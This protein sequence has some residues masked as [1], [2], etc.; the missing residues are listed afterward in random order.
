M[1][2]ERN[3]DDENYCAAF[4]EHSAISQN[5][6]ERINRIKNN[7]PDLTEFSPGP[8]D[9][10]QFT[11]LAWELLGGYIANNDHLDYI[12]LSV[13]GLTDSKISLLFQGLAN[14]SPLKELDLSHNNLGV[15]GVRRMVPFLESARNLRELCLSDNRDTNTECFRLLIKAL[16]AGGGY[17]QELR[18]WDGKIEDITSLEHYPLPHL[19]VLY[20]SKNNIHS[21]PTSLE[22]YTNLEELHL[23]NNQIGNEGCRSIAKLLQK[24]GTHL[25]LLNLYSNDLGDEDAETLADSLKYNTSLTDIHLEGNDIKEKGHRAFL[26]LVNDVSSIERTYNSNHTLK[27]LS[28]PRSTDA[29]IQEFKTHIES[30]MGINKYE[31]R[32]HGRAKVIEAQLNSKNRK[33]LSHLQGID[34]S[35]GSIFTEIEP[36]LLP[37]VFALMGERY[38]QDEL[39]EMLITAAPDLVS[40]VNI[41][42][43][44]K[45]TNAE[46]LARIAA[47]EAEAAAIKDEVH[48]LNEV[49]TS[50]ESEETHQPMIGRKRGRE[51][52]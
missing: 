50:F 48:E 9:T 1:E 36:I 23:S 3:S 11:D 24:E 21:L 44:I 26:K 7:D 13:C 20:L 41:K 47:L 46:K 35:Q 37:E 17:I 33:E 30:A 39:Y 31:E 27:T 51:N 38:G 40:I 10:E 34:Y 12:D 6:I 29:A 14:G 4:G 16:H 22:N 32:S 8:A 52:L 28:L 15:D 43:V 42:G 45:Q 18:L 19:K 5:C 49:L 2:S 25:N